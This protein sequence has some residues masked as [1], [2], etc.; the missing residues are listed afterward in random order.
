MT[1]RGTARV[2][3]LSFLQAGG[4]RF[5]TCTAHQ[6]NQ[7]VFEI[8]ESGVTPELTPI[9]PW[10]PKSPDNS[11]Q[12]SYTVFAASPI[13][14][15]CFI[16]FSI[17]REP[18]SICVGGPPYTGS[19]I[20]P[21]APSPWRSPIPE[22]P[23]FTLTLSPLAGP[24]GDVSNSIQTTYLSS[25]ISILVEPTP[26][27]VTIPETIMGVEQPNRSVRGQNR[28]LYFAVAGRRIGQEVCY[29]LLCGNV[30]G[31]PLRS[32]GASALASLRPH[33]PQRPPLRTSVGKISLLSKRA[34]SWPSS[35]VAAVHTD[36]FTMNHGEA[37]DARAEETS[38]VVY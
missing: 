26:T 7:R 8:A 2:I 15:R 25:V 29:E 1:H 11:G 31:T 3:L 34:R 6:V 33:R 13:Q 9:D 36:D 28:S 22:P 18:R 16:Y 12:L 21:G 30:R 38:L 5:E 14:S 32:G 23:V 19:G 37:A 10:G 17:E 4:R 35:S 27:S 24:G 20:M